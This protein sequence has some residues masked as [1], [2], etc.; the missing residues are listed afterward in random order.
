MIRRELDYVRG[1]QNFGELLRFDR[2]FHAVEALECVAYL[3]EFSI[4]AEGSVYAAS[5]GAD[6]RPDENCLLYPGKIKLEIRSML[7]DGR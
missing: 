4:A 3:S 5:E 6:I 7:E 1:E 2:L